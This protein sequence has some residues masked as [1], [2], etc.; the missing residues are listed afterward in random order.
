[1]IYSN[2]PDKNGFQP[3][4]CCV[5]ASSR[6]LRPPFSNKRTCPILFTMVSRRCLISG[7]RD[8]LPV[9]SGLGKQLNA[10]Q[11]S[12]V[13]ERPCTTSAPACNLY[14]TCICAIVLVWINCIYTD[15]TATSLAW[16][17]MVTIPNCL[18]SACSGW[19]LGDVKFEPKHYHIVSTADTAAPQARMGH[20]ELS[21]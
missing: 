5:M 14:Y 19:W 9:Y 8:I 7:V 13:K 6:H 10:F 20:T 2:Y 4:W 21:C 11:V 12:E 16:C 3:I 1:M 15:L 17:L 18:I